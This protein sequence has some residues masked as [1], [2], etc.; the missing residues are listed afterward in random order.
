[1]SQVSMRQLLE[2]GVHFGHR[3]RYWNPKMAPYIFGHRNKIHIIN[4]EETLPLIKDAYNY[5]S[6]LADNGGSIMFVGTKRA[7]REAI[8]KQARRAGMPYV[9]HRWLGGMLT[10]FK[11]VKNSIQRLHDLEQ[12]I[13]DGSIKKLNK[14]EGLDLQR[15]RD[16]LDRGIGGIKEMT[17]LPDALFVVDVGFEKIAIDEARKLGIPV[18]AIVDTNC[19]PEG[20]DVVIPG[21]DDAIR[22]IRIY[23]EMVADAVL[24]GRGS[25]GDF[26]AAEDEFV[27]VPDEGLEH[28]PGKP[29]ASEAAAETRENLATR[30]TVIQESESE[31]EPGATASP[32][33]VA[34][35]TP[36]DR[37]DAD[38]QENADK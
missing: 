38:P 25:K 18:I 1:M 26:T 15:E 4:L 7:A 5:I 21:N 33:D 31:S 22:A 19:S 2:A 29:A 17:S 12:M 36:E 8:G 9:N 3:T 34:A 11:T 14:R 37:K 10:N 35:V 32:S 28:A 27:E 16:K 6:R 24:A 30:N 23:S 13:E 20:I